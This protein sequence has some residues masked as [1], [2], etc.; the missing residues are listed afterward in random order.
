MSGGE[1]SKEKR[2]KLLKQLDLPEHTSSNALLQA[3]NLLMDIEEL[4]EI[5][6]AN[7]D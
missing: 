4:R 5:I 6:G 3:I 2:L 7:D 1:N